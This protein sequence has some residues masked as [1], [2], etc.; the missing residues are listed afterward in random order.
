MEGIKIKMLEFTYLG[1]FLFYI[2]LELVD[3][4]WKIITCVVY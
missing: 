1:Y 2:Q 4:Y 3:T